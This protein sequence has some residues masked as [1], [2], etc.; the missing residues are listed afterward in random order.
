MIDQDELQ[1]QV[2]KVQPSG[3]N[4]DSNDEV[5]D[6]D[7]NGKLSLGIAISYRIPDCYRQEGKQHIK[8]QAVCNGHIKFQV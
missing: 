4:D 7:P 5:G 2:T 6:Y 3:N 8:N 1:D